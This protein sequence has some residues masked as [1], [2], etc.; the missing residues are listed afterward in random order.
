MIHLV[1]RIA[2][3]HIGLICMGL[4][5]MVLS[6]AKCADGQTQQKAPEDFDVVSIRLH[7]TG[8]EVIQALRAR[9]GVDPAKNL[10][11]GKKPGTYD[12][13]MTYVPYVQYRAKNFSVNVEFV[14]VFPVSSKRREGAHA[15]A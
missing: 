4:M 11:I 7:R 13:R 8:A 14:E 10:I 12:P 15:V 3:F 9:F 5:S 2:F 1:K 6:L